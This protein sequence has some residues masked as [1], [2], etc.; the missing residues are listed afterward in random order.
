MTKVVSILNLKGGVAKTTL[1]VALADTFAIQ[2]K[3][4]LVV[5]LDPQC[6]TSIMLIGHQKWE[7]LHAAEK[8][9]A[10]Y[11][12]PGKK[13]FEFTRCVEHAVSDIT[14]GGKV[15]Q[16]ISLLASDIRLADVQDSVKDVKVMP[17]ALT[18]L[19]RSV[20][21][22]DLILIDCPPNFGI[23]TR[24]AISASS[25]YIIPA[26]PDYLS[27]TLGAARTKRNVKRFKTPPKLAGIV[28]T[29]YQKGNSTQ[30][31]IASSPNQLN[32]GLWDDVLHNYHMMQSVN[33]ANAAFFNVQK[34]AYTAKYPDGLATTLKGLAMELW[35]R[36]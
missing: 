11:F 18:R 15:I 26:I 2:G 16:N 25:S 33:F 20:V 35:G 31:M 5:D 13:S 34:R 22:F 14:F 1:T 24:N 8:T 36:F 21:G 3:K 30:H 12:I 17:G 23:F 7:A 29:K 10:S 9:L 4:V 6:D 19:L 28:I 27:F 32:A